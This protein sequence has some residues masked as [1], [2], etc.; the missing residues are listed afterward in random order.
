MRLISNVTCVKFRKRTHERNY[1]FIHYGGV[2]EG[3]L[4]PVGMQGNRQVIFLSK[5]EPGYYDC[6]QRVHT[7]VHEIMHALGCY[8][9]MMRPD[10]DNYVTIVRD[11][12]Q[13][14]AFFFIRYENIDKT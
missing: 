6:A 14:G 3:C 7:I 9:E 10:R 1:V 12:I 11:N 5:G 2:G 4:G 13:K 8:H